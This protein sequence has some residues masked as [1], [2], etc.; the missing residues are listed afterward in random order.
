MAAAGLENAELLG[1]TGASTSKKTR[2][3]LFR[4]RKPA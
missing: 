2:G 4:A 3:A 1:H